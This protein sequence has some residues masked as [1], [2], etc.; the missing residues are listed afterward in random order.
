MHTN[1]AN[2]NDL[3]ALRS[4]AK[5][6]RIAQLISHLRNL[7]CTHNAL[8]ITASM[9]LSLLCAG[10]LFKFD[11]VR[12]AID[13]LSLLENWTIIVFISSLMMTFANSYI[14][15]EDVISNRLLIVM[16]LLL[17]LPK[18]LI[19]KENKAKHKVEHNAEHDSEVFYSNG[20]AQSS[21]R[22]PP[23][24]TCSQISK[25][26]LTFF[27]LYILLTRVFAWG[28]IRSRLA[29]ERTVEVMSIF[30]NWWSLHVPV[31]MQRNGVGLVCGCLMWMIL[32]NTMVPS[33]VNRK[34]NAKHK[35]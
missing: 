29:L 10:S 13:T 20:T 23:Q 26:E 9:T 33:I 28:T 22:S 8:V 32:E 5:R 3:F 16:L 27:V 11:E 24:T 2:D 12:H 18:L 30:D 35:I 25:S 21:T 14:E 34:Y 7:R 17:T 15:Q 4:S 6:I 1:D 31:W 19:N